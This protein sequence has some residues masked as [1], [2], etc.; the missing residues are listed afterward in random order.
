MPL[1]QRRI[2]NF[3]ALGYLKLRARLEGLRWLMSYKL[4]PYM[5]DTITEQVV[6]IH[7]H[8]TLFWI[9][10][11]LGTQT[12]TMKR[13]KKAAVK[14]SDRTPVTYLLSALCQSSRHGK[15][16]VGLSTTNKA[17]SPPN[18]NTKDYKSVAFLSIFRMPSPL[19]KRKAPLLK[20]FW[21][22]FCPM[23]CFIGLLFHTT[24]QIN[25][26]NQ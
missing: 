16:F 15:A 13:T 14:L 3:G 9:P 19:H 10:S 22:R 1:D 20:I 24:Q 17:P 12:V 26:S 7:K 23:H 6:P 5:L 25:K 21:R 18:W 2:F 11:T 4:A 8:N